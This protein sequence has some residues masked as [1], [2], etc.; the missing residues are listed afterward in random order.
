MASRSRLNPSLG[1]ALS[2]LTAGK[3]SRVIGTFW[4]FK[5]LLDPER[6][7]FPVPTFLFIALFGATC[8]LLPLQRPWKGKRLGGKRIRKVQIQSRHLHL[9]SP[10]CTHHLPEAIHLFCASIILTETF[11]IP[12]APSE[13]LHLLFSLFS[14]CVLPPGVVQWNRVR[15]NSLPVVIRTLRMWTPEDTASRRS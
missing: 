15:T 10:P 14:P 2:L 4:A 3:G 13:S 1:P 9:S 11:L 5:T 8:F 12:A 7:K 6:G